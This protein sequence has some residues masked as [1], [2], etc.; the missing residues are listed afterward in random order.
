MIFIW[1]A[2]AY[3]WNYL[4]YLNAISGSRFV[5]VRLY[6]VKSDLWNKIYLYKTL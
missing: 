1:E 2:N 4:R 6:S 5:S 3:L